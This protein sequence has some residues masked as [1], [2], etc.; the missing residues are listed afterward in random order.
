MNSTENIIALST[1]PG[2]SAIAVIRLSGPHVIKLVNSL[3]KS[4]D[5]EQQKG[6]TLSF[7]SLVDLSGEMLD[8]VVIAL[9]K[10]PMSYTGQDVVEISCHGSPYIVN[11]IL[12][13]FLDTGQVRHA[14]P[15]EFTQRAFLN[16]K[17]NLIEAEAIANLIEADNPFQ[18][19]VALR[20]L[21]SGFSKTL[22]QLRD[23][24]IHFASLLELELDFSEENLIF[25]DRSHL[26]NLIDKAKTQVSKLLDSFQTA[27]VIKQG[28]AVALVG[29]PNVGKSTLL[30]ALAKEDKAIVSDIPGTTR[31]PIEAQILIDGLIFRFVD[32][33]GLRQTE[34]TLEQLG[35]KRTE[36]ALEKSDI[37]VYIY[38]L[39]QSTA[40]DSELENLRRYAK[41]VLIV[42]NK[43]DLHAV[44]KTSHLAISA[45]NRT[46]LESLKR[47]LLNQIQIDKSQIQNVVTTSARH[48]E[49]LKTI[50]E[51]LELISQN[52]DREVSSDLL[53]LDFRN[54]L[55]AL[56]ELT[57]EITNEAVLDRIFRDFCIG[58]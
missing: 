58:K 11:L 3:F 27:K 45:K 29:K 23:D 51:T 56:G 48:Y 32:T 15:G 50:L 6:H 26:K 55:Q 35:I 24:L 36:Q 2:L 47:A 20:Q 37:I 39:S 54:A 5:L 9:F 7:G 53:V 8:E 16:G 19:R 42:A 22:Q 13:N 28:V 41:P 40:E 17:L 14:S 57:G 34:D 33:A 31:D 18:H 43:I 30:N 38:D 52:L 1:P 49:S 4:K 25:A 21:Q 44:T 10:A 46:G 12:Q